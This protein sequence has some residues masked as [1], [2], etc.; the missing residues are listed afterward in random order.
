MVS[1]RY[2]QY[3]LSLDRTHG[4]RKKKLKSTTFLRENI[5]IFRNWEFK[6]NEIIFCVWIG[7]AETE[8]EVVV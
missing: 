6:R 7:H 5:F 4:E 1:F 2:S 3:S 8:G